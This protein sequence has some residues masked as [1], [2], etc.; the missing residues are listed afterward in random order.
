M[1][2]MQTPELYNDKEQANHTGQTGVQQVLPVL[3]E[4]HTA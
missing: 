3:S 4:A 1:Q 2:R